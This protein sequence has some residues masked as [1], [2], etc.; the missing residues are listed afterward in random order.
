MELTI[1]GH[2][3]DLSDSL[4]DYA[5]RRL[6]FSLGGFAAQLKGVEVRV[7]DINGPRGGIDKT[8]AIRVVMRKFGV[9]FVRAAGADAYST[10]DRAAARIQSA[11]S[12]TLSRRQDH[13]RHVISRPSRSLSGS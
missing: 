13:R 4:R 9:M 2:G 11:V 1:K 8:C 5:A 3:L 12:R 6:R 10:I 7:G